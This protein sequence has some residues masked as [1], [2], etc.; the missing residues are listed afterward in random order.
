M[1]LISHL[2]IYF[3]SSALSLWAAVYF[4]SGFHVKGDIQTIALVVLLFTALNIVI[5]PIIKLIF[6]P[7]I[8]LTLGAGIVLVNAVMLYLLDY[9]SQNVSINSIMALLYAAL[10]MSVVNILVHFSVKHLL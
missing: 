1:K 10:I 8:I 4:I 7:V 5:R 2:I 9:F 3:L 6:S